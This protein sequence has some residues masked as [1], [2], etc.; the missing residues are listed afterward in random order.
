VVHF[1]DYVPYGKGRPRWISSTFTPHSDA[2]GAVVGFF[3]LM[4]DITERKHSER[5]LA[6]SLARYRFLA[7]AMP[8]NVWTADAEGRQDYV[9]RRWVEYTGLSADLGARDRWAEIVH[10]DDGEPTMRRWLAAVRTGGDYR[11]EHRLRDA[12]GEYHW[13][14]SLALGRRD[15]TGRVVQWVGTAT[16][17]DEQRLAYAKLVE[18]RAELR[19]RADNLEDEVRLRTA[20]LEEVNAELEAF[21][22]SAS[23]DLRVPLHHIQS[24]ADAILED[25]AMTLSPEGHANMRM[26]QV[27]SRRMDRLIVDLLAYSRLSHAEIQ[28][29][30]IDLERMVEQVLFDLKVTVTAANAVIEVAHPLPTVAADGTGLRQVLTNLLANALKFV[31]PGRRPTVMIRAERRAGRVRLWIQDNGIGID[32]SQHDAIFKIFH[33]LHGNRQ[34][35][36]TGIGL[37]LVKR[38]MQRMGGDCGVESETGSG[39]RFWVEFRAD[40]FAGATDASSI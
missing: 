35:E 18:A 27:A 25:G 33:R 1:E 15:E 11:M 9:N 7:D 5:E 4:I 20:R 36:G 19:R 21:T 22:S 26:I 12:S 16:N 29:G 13:F 14:L 32:A 6:E 28:I 23:H 17:I 39:S 3:A 31:A 30:P 37:S 8:Q 34:Y 40:T 24:F 2:D 38:A 10:P